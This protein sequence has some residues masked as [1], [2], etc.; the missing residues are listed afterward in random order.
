MQQMYDISTSSPFSYAALDGMG[1]TRAYV[2][3]NQATGEYTMPLTAANLEK[4]LAMDNVL[5]VEQVTYGGETF[6]HNGNGWTES[7]YGPLWIPAKGA[8]VSLTL[9]N[10]P[11]YERIIDVYEENDLRVEG[12]DIYING[13]PATEYTFRMDYYWMMGDNRQNSADS[14]FWGFVPEDHIVGKASF[15]WLSL[16]AEKGWFDGKIRWS[17][18]FRKIW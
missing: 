2:I 6:P 16:D 14:R 7:D 9:E 12:G 11:F 4:V 3:Y 10:L 15:V 8:T 17:K 18:M 13:A 1:I 5:A